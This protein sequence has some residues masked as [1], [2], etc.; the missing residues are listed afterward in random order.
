MNKVKVFHE[1][2]YRK[3]EEEIN[4]FAL[5]HNIL[6]TSICTEKH[7]YEVYYTIIIVYEGE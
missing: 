4:E 2:H 3:L 6:N 7:G 1:E 5:K